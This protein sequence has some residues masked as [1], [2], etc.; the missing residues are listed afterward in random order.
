MTMTT[1]LTMGDQ[2]GLKWDPKNLEIRTMSVEKTLEPLVLQVTTLVNT[3]GPSKKKKGKS[4]RANALVQ[5]V[6]KATENFIEK[7]EQI[8]YENPDIT[9]EMLAAVDEVRKTGTQMS[10]DAREFSEDPCS[11]IKRSNMVRAARNL[12]SA[13]TRLLILADMVDVHLLLKSLHIVENDLEKLKMASSN[14]EL[15]NNIETF[16]HNAN[17]LMNQAAK[18]QQELKDPHLR[19]DLAAA[20][21]V[22][23]KH[24]TMLLTASKVY[25]RHP[26]LAAAKANRD[27]VLKQVCEA[28]NTI[29][30]VA[31]GRAPP[32]AGPYDGPGELAAALDDFDEHIVIEP[33]AYNEVHTR[34]SLE[35]RLE[36]IISG[37]ALMA[38]SSCTRD[39]RRE[40]IVA[41]CN[42]VRQ[43]L[44]DLLSEYMSNQLEVLR[45]I[46]GRMGNKDKTES[47]GKAI[48]N[49]KGK[50]KDLRRQLRKAVVDHISDSFMETSIPL[51]ILIK[52][53]QNGDEK[54]V[55]EYAGVFTEHSNKLVEVAAL[56][57]SMSSHEDGVK[58]VRYA[59]AQIDSLCPEVI[60]AARILA[61]RPR[62]KVAQ[63]NMDAF[64]LTWENQVRILTD[65][66]DDI[67]TVDDFLAVSENHILEDVNKC[68]LA[69]QENEADTLERTAAAIRGRTGRIGVVVAAEM[70]NYE[71]CIYTKRV[72]E[73]VKV[74]NDQVMPKFTQRV[75]VAVQ[76]IVNS[77]QGQPSK[78]LDENEFIDA[79][80][81][82]YDGVR[83]IRRA[84]LMNRADEDLD[85]EDVELDENYTLETKSKSSAHTGEH[86]VDEYP[87]ISGITT[88]REAMGKM[89]EEDRKKILQ[90]V[91]YFRSEKLKFDREVAKWDDTGNDIIVLAKHMCVIMMEM[92]DFTRGRGPLKTTMD[93]INA[94]K[95]ISEAGTKLDKLTRQIA[96]QCP[97]SSTKKDLLA[98]LQRIA[99]YCHQMNITSKVKADVQNISGE[100]I[101][102]GLDSATSLIQ[103]AKNLMN[104]VVLTVK[105]SYVAS[106][107][108][109]RQGTVASPI[110]V[111]KM[112]APEKKPLVRPEKP[113]EVRAKV[114]KGSQKK[115]QNPIHAL[116]EFQSPTESV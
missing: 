112:K 29:N 36:S 40:R 26:E 90:Q 53:A 31:Q 88:A 45:G 23:K 76:A 27:Y 84:V 46:T 95:K 16:R 105:A 89:P 116:S 77:Q 54:Q 32:A 35:E 109:P 81:L 9:Q 15:L 71:P 12:L 28:V 24:S 59:A 73:A 3:N 66:I 65:A 22:L 14:D 10:R 47:L 6:E 34:P 5:T 91:E 25:V 4:K 107:K 82:V 41:E 63:E 75:Q 104:A 51:L 55:E 60:N 33:L 96:E 1:T 100:L 78:E 37:A 99:L 50:T 17:E 87:E 2:F 7:G 103:A 44:Q 97:E 111:W 102:S 72:L 106:T 85:P 74:L 30:D 48:D 67:T 19:D 79:S 52:A 98:Y 43:A 113:E 114:R 80:R 11:S 18:R 110:V 38:D 61:A 8:A 58:M 92:T 108:Y 93:V 70:D 21:A 94:A 39:D 62:S 64:R 49:M 101:V 69:L 20:R 83:E 42:A 13:V 115:L 68:V 86:G 56:V 57:C